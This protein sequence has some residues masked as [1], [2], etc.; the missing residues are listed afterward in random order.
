MS[1]FMIAADDPRVARLRKKDARLGV[2]FDLLGDVEFDDYSDGYSFIV[3]EIVGQMISWRVAEILC[4]RLKTLCNG[5]ICPRTIA[6]FP[7]AELRSI[8]LSRPKCEYIQG[9]TEAV[10]NG[11]LVLEELENV[12]DEEA[13]KRLTAIKGIGTWTAKMY[14]LCV[15]RRDDVFPQEDKQLVAAYKWLYNKEEAT[16]DDLKKLRERWSPYSSVATLYLYRAVSSGLTNRPFSEYT[17][18][19][20]RR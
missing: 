19:A 6:R 16:R 17:K 11:E 20:K 1:R 12:S 10:L 5:E 9:F 4:D 14:L 13:M 7:T 15:L 8:G 3:C 2:V 18:A